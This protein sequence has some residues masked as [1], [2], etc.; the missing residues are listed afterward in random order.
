MRR[1]KQFAL[2]GIIA[3]LCMISGALAQDPVKSDSTHYK[4]EF[5]NDQVRVLRVTYGPN[6]KSVMHEHPNSVAVFLTD[7]QGQ[8][9]FPDG[10][11]VPVEGKAGQV[12]WDQAGKHLPENKSDKPFQ[13]IVVELKSTPAA[14]KK[15]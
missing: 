9:T 2:A 10:K 7:A 12:I 15:N 4:V 3:V 13:V 6:E 11:T 1:S 14:M 5:E 8:F